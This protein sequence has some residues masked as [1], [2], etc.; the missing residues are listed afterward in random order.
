MKIINTPL[1]NL[2]ILQPSIY[3]DKRGYFLE[4]FKTDFFKNKFGFNIIQ[5]NESKSSFGVLRGL[6]FQTPPFEQS[7]IVRVIKGS[8]LDVVVDLR[9]S[10][11]T[12][13]Q[14][15]NIKIDEFNKKQ[16]FIPKGFAHGFIVLSAEAI[17]HYSVDNVYSK[18]HETGIIWNDKDL[19]VN[20][21][22]NNGD[23]IV[24]E[25][26]KLLPSFSKSF[27]FL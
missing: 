6:H 7:K 18:E 16:L 3:N 10:S 11:K 27:I 23:I 8:I 17:V 15:F 9:K 26:D 21:E 24:S 22:V 5:Q 20:W 4:T 14:H 1:D 13:G 19:S 2:K 12:F 25:K